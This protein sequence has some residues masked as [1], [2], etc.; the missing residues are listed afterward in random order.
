MILLDTDHLSIVADSRDQFHER[1]V[2]RLKRE[3]VS[4][5]ATSIVSVEEQ[6]RG[7]LGK[8]RWSNNVHRQVLGYGRL[9]DLFLLLSHWNIVTFDD[10][11][12]DEF[13]RL[14]KGGVGIGTQDLKIAAIAVVHGACL[15][16]ANLR[17][18]RRVPGL[19]VEDWLRGQN[20][21]E[22]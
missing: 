1:L 22:S 16:S 3:P 7:W 21:E 11:A 5:L 18:F 12:A 13:K 10:R 17:D 4:S 8:I 15:L 2:A 19:R 14:R 9:R 20:P 6:C